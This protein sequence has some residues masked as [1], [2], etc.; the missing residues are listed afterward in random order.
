MS[1]ATHSG[2]AR[3]DVVQGGASEGRR[4]AS[5][6]CVMGMGCVQVG[7][8]WG[9]G[10]GDPVEVGVMWRH[11]APAV[12]GTVQIRGATQHTICD[13]RLQSLTKILQWKI[14]FKKSEQRLTVT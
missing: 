14:Q 10:H 13:E 3:P 1:I 11:K 9:V 5:K 6:G 12:I 2:G 8:V 4:G 7:E